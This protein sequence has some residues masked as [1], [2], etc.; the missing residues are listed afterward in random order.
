VTRHKPN[1]KP[2]KVTLTLAAQELEVTREHLSRVLHS[3][4]V[5]RS[6]LRRYRELIKQHGAELP[7][8][9]ALRVH[10]EQPHAA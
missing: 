8:F 7:D 4:R 2:K 3:H 9:P 10:G 5:S 6:L 1:H